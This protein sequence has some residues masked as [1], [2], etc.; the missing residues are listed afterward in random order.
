MRVATAELA[1]EQRQG[2]TRA[3]VAVERR[4]L[5]QQQLAEEIQLRQARDT[6]QWVG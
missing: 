6:L 3:C 2:G 1:P 5:Q 4:E